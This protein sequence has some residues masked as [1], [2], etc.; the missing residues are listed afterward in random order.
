MADQVYSY[1]KKMILSGDL[2]GG[3]RVPE[4]KIARKF[5]ISRTPVR[6][7][8]KRLDEYGLI[9]IKPR[10]YA[11]VVNLDREEAV[12]IAMIRAQL[13]ILSVS[14]L[15]DCGKE[16]EFEILEKLAKEHT[17]IIAKGDIAGAYEKDSQ[18]HL[19]IAE[20][21]N[22]K[23]LFDVYMK[24]DAKVQLSRLSIHLP[25]DRL[26]IYISQHKDIVH[27]MKS[28]NKRIAKSLI[29]KHILDQIKDFD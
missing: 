29:Q 22:N 13:E 7:A 1:I 9:K 27:A 19:Q 17:E 23:H 6:E 24:I 8:L 15:T 4:E 20:F 3:E 14:I 16:T 21:T 25:L 26:I 5:G 10:S 2:E 18:F 11:V 28:R 12:Q